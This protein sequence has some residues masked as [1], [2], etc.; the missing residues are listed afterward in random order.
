LFKG[1]GNRVAP[2][3]FTRISPYYEWILEASCA[4]TEDKNSQL[5]PDMACPPS[6]GVFGYP[7]AEVPN[8]S[9]FVKTFHGYEPK[10]VS[11]SPPAGTPFNSNTTVLVVAVDE[12]DHIALCAW[13]LFFPEVRSLF[14]IYE[15]PLRGTYEIMHSFPSNNFAI[16]DGLAIYMTAKLYRSLDGNATVAV[17][18]GYSETL[19]LSG[20]DSQG[21]LWFQRPYNPYNVSAITFAVTKIKKRNPISVS[22]FGQLKQYEF[23]M[24]GSMVHG[25]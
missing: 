13:D 23:V 14:D 15:E 3:G 11:Q 20:S 5:C 6:D 9:G 1:C 2:S 16:Y 25:E 10:R 17:T 4:L 12:S 19:T 7:W 22:L 24:P 21:E 8:A 18:A